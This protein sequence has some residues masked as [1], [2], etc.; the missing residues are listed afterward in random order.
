VADEPSES[1]LALDRDVILAALAAAGPAG[2]NIGAWKGKVNTLIPEVAAMLS[3]HSRQMYRAGLIREASVFKAIYQG[4]EFEESSQRCK[5]WINTGKVSRNYPEGIEPIRTERCDTGPGAAMRRKLDQISSGQEI[6]VYKAM[7]RM[8]SSEE[9]D[10]VRLLMHFELAF[11]KPAEQAA[12]PPTPA[13]RPA[14]GAARTPAAAPEAQTVDGE[15]T[16]IQVANDAMNE[17]KLGA[18][19]KTAVVK[20]AAKQGLWP[21][22]PETLDAVLVLIAFE[23]PSPTTEETNG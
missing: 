23:A 17:S 7:E 11:S 16:A 22:T 10:K 14:S 15:R 4:Y 5:V 9:G 12:L 1:E 6:Y 8:R 2:S 13:A 19:A 3:S 18:K 20:E 21:P